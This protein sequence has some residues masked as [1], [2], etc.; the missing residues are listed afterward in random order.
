MVFSQLTFSPQISGR[1]AII[2]DLALQQVKRGRRTAYLK[3]T[4]VW[5]KAA[6]LVML[7]LSTSGND[8]IDQRELAKAF[9]ENGAKGILGMLENVDGSI[10]RQIMKAFFVEYRHNP[11]LPIPEIL[12]RLRESIVQQLDNQLTDEMCH[13][14]LAT[15]LYAYYGH[16]LAVLKLTPANL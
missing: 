9:L 2:S 3:R 12:R 4:K 11:D 8:E 1:I 14:Y 13:L 10:S 5:Q 7:H 15:F 6:S 16:P